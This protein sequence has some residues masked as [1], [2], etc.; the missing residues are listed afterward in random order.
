LAFSQSPSGR[1]GGQGHQPEIQLAVE[2]RI[3]Q[4]GRFFR[5]IEGLMVGPGQFHPLAGAGDTLQPAAAGAM[6]GA[7]GG[8]QRQCRVAA[9]GAENMGA[10]AATCSSRTAAAAWPR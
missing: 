10:T 1:G 6:F 5:Q 3:W 7:D 8:A 2:C 4:T 9:H